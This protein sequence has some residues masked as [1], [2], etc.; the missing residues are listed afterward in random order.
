MSTTATATTTAT[1]LGSG[2]WVIDP[3]H[4]RV[5]FEVAHLGISTFRGSFGEFEGRIV[6]AG[7][8]L[9]SVEGTIAPASVDVGDGQLAG[10]LRSEDFFA[11]ERHPV[12]SFRSTSVQETGEGSYRLDG[13][14]TLRGVTRPLGLDVDVDGVGVGPDSSGRIAL[15]GRGELDRTEYGIEWNSRLANGASM[16]GERVRLVLSVEAAEAE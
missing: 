4:S 1:D 13:E 15:S 10:H 3:V 7:G 2:T 11:T 5:G 14:L 6:T 12:A 8:S 16:V 9:A